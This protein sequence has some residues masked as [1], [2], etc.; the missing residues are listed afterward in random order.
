MIWF[1]IKLSDLDNEAFGCAETVDVGTWLRLAH[2]CCVQ[3]NYGRIRGA[4]GWDD[5]K[6]LFL[7]R[8]TK[9]E[10]LRECALWSWKNDDLLVHHFPLEKLREV[11]RLRSQ[12]AEAARIRWE[13][14][15]AKRHAAGMPEGMPSGMRP[16]SGRNAELEGK[17]KGRRKEGEG[18]ERALSLVASNPPSREQVAAFIAQH[19]GTPEL[20]ADFHDTFTANGWTQGGRPEAPLRSWEP[21]ATKWLR[22]AQRDGGGKKSF[23]GAGAAAAFDPKSPHAHTGGIPAA[24]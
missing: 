7:C 24:N 14:E 13:K 12:A 23:E 15:P 20:A 9:A 18:K 1:N 4:R 10:V 2:Y 5:R 11:K 3:E 8:L 16:Q 6:W 17:E 22:R 21:E 19:G